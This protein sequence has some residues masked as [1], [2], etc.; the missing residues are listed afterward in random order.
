M[1]LLDTLI[2]PNSGAPLSINWEKGS[3]DNLNLDVFHGKIINGVPIIL[4]KNKDAVESATELHEQS[5]TEFNYIDH[6][7]KDAE[8]FDY[9]EKSDDVTENERARLNQK[10]IRQ[11]SKNSKRIL[12]VGCGNGWLSK[13]IQNDQNQVVSMDIALNNVQKA[14]LNE[15]HKNHSGLVADVFHLPFEKNSFDSIVASE[16][17]EH[18]YDPKKFIEC[19]F[20]VLKPGGELIITTPFDEKIPLYL[21]VHCNKS[22]PKNAHLHSFN[23]ANIKE[24]I[25]AQVKNWDYTKITNKYL[26]KARVYWLLRKVPFTIWSGIDSLANKIF[27]KPTRLVIVI[28]K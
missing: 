27:K 15:P 17:I 2:D 23:D 24:V 4:P 25:P 3:I 6:Y 9:H 20:Q 21:C 28:K 16:I 5:R 22:T 18:V 12:D 8:I 1:T 14:L 11:I 13:A 10:I 26:L 19:L 7:E